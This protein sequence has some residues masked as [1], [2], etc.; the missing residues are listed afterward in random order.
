MGAVVTQTASSALVRARARS[1]VRLRLRFRVRA[2]ARA[3]VRV[4]VRVWLPGED[5]L[6]GVA[7]VVDDAL[8]VRGVGLAAAVRL[9]VPCARAEDHRPPRHAA[10]PRGHALAHVGGGHPVEKHLRAR[11]ARELD[12]PQLETVGEPRRGR[13][14]RRPGDA[15]ADAHRERQS[16]SRAPVVDVCGQ[17]PHG[18][19]GPERAGWLASASGV[20]EGAPTGAGHQREE[21]GQPKDARH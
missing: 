17:L 2:R 7:H 3:R 16:A 20:D 11:R 21:H 8:Q 10:H 9:Q 12:A 14:A 13:T 1:R 15:V 6:H 19:V 18:A 5:R 4:R